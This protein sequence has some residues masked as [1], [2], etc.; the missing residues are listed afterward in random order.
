MSKS[1]RV[2]PEKLAEVLCA[3]ALTKAGLHGGRTPKPS[4]TFW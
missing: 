2:F 3:S 4:P 1:K